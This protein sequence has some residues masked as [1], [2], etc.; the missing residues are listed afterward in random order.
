MEEFIDK[1]IGKKLKKA[2]EKCR[3]CSKMM[4]RHAKECKSHIQFT[5]LCHAH[6][7]QVK[8]I[9]KIQN[10]KS[11]LKV[12]EPEMPY[13]VDC[14]FDTS[15]NYNVQIDESFSTIRKNSK[16]AGKLLESNTFN[17]K[18]DLLHT[19]P[20]IN[21]M[22]FVNEKNYSLKE[23]MET[24]DSQL[25]EAS[26]EEEELKFVPP[27]YNVDSLSKNSDFCWYV[28]KLANDSLESISKEI[29]EGSALLAVAELLVKQSQLKFSKSEVAPES[30][31]SILSPLKVP[32]TFK[33]LKNLKD[34]LED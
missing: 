8:K 32:K 10:I 30:G 1:C 13:V 4:Q 29:F 17:V 9:L 3:F 27:L 19:H 5:K 34:M 15:A 6:V 23:R 14:I 22:M 2:D 21:A 33:E 7:L 25:C 26:I 11:P 16:L 24:F 31:V 20:K 18:P 28:N 12:E